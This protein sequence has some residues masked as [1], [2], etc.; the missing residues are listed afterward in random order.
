MKSN[1]L[2]L[3]ASAIVV[4]AVAA[5]LFFFGGSATTVETPRTDTPAGAYTKYFQKKQFT[6][7][8]GRKSRVLTY[9]WFEPE[10]KPYPEGL[11]FP[12]V[13]M[14]HGAPGNAYAAQYLLQGRRS[15]EYP[16]FIL[17]PMSGP[18]KIWAVPEKLDG[19]PVAARYLQNQALPDA[20]AMT[21][22]LAREHPVDTDRIYVIGCSDGG[23]GSYAAAL[24]Y[25][26]I[27]AASVALS[28]IWDH[29]DGP[30][31]NKVPIWIMHGAL[32]GGQSS[33]RARA[34]ADAIHRNGGN[35]LF[36]EFP[37]MG[38]ECPSPRLYPEIMWKWMFSQSKQA[39]PG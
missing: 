25:P 16:A 3:A 36:T 28:G 9:Y 14:L 20:V 35:V 15:V 24:R 8:E 34:T 4:A 11:K 26:D 21:A 17:I 33:A 23:G 32:D 37:D 7:K 5:S 10:G 1:S 27:F 12:L 31:M 6:L 30:R 19:K 2:A 13:V 18:G 38:H 39:Q 22:Q 29:M